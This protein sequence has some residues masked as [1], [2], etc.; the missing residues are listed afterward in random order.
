MK[1]N[2]K[3]NISKL[4]NLNFKI[5][6]KQGYC[7]VDEK[8]N[9]ITLIFEDQY[10]SL[11]YNMI[12]HKVR[13]YKENDFKEFLSEYK[14]FMIVPRDSSTYDDYKCGDMVQNTETKDIG[15]VETRVDNMICIH[16]SGGD[17][18]F[19]WITYN[20]AFSKNYRLINTDYEI[21]LIGGSFKFGDKVLVRHSDDDSWKMRFYSRTLDKLFFV[22]EENSVISS[23]CG[24][25]QCIPYNENTWGLLGTTDNYKER[26]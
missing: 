19:E 7:K 22:R 16:W 20:L 3:Y 5:G 12:M 2:I 18:E 25:K 13:N 23:D 10:Y 14:N 26:D 24:Y 11:Y 17:I 4:N 15:R 21:D 1:D 8:N 9:N 6:D